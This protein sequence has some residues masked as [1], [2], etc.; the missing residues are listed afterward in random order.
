MADATSW[1]TVSD[2]DQFLNRVHPI[3]NDM[4]RYSLGDRDDF[5]VDHQ[6]PVILAGDEA[7]DNHHAIARFAFRYGKELAHF[8]FIFEID[9]NAPTMVAV[10]RFDHHRIADASGRANRVIL[11][12]NGGAAR[13]RD[14]GFVEQFRRKLFVPGD[15]DGNV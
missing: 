2:I 1:V 8:G 6:D 9:A 10:E 13:H 15:I 7:F 4:R 14:A 12:A 5:T 3:A 11:V